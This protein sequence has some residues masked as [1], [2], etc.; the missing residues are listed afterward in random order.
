MCAEI[1]CCRAPRPGLCVTYTLTRQ[2]VTYPLSRSFTFS[3]KAAFRGLPLKA[4]PV[5]Q[6]MNWGMY[7][8][9]NGCGPLLITSQPLW[10]T[11]IGNFA[12]RSSQSTI[13]AI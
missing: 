10:H 9:C 12:T 1:P 13:G 5:T 3:V 11:P 6:F 8:V 2:H 7:T 4:L